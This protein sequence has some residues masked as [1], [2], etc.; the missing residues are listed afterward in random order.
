MKS[1][2]LD[3]STM[4]FKLKY[5]TKTVRMKNCLPA[6]EGALCFVTTSPK[7][8]QNPTKYAGTQQGCGRA[9]VLP[10]MPHWDRG[11]RTDSFPHQQ[12]F[13]FLEHIKDSCNLL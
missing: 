13:C 8:E 7:S 5:Q 2:L 3:Q 6:P 1:M 9:G 10:C 12:T 4:D 11:A